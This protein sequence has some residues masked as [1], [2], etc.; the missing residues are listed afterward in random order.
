MSEN[1]FNKL[2]AALNLIGTGIFFV[3]LSGILG[4]YHRL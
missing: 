1:Q 3:W 2:M 4:C